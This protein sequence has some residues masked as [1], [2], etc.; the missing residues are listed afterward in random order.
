MEAPHERICE[1]SLS[2]NHIK[3]VYS[4]SARK[5]PRGAPN[6]SMVKK[7]SLSVRKIEQVTRFYQKN[8]VQKRGP[9]HCGDLKKNLTDTSAVLTIGA[10]CVTI[11]TI[12]TIGNQ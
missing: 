11:G 6:S 3:H 12:G 4:T 8:K 7:S 9:S 2:F 10:E 5:L 1:I